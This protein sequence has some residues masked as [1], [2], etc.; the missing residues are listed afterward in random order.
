MGGRAGAGLLSPGAFVAAC[1]VMALWLT[2]L[3][4]SVPT[5]QLGAAESAAILKEATR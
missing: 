1:V 2:T 4:A 5:H 3:T